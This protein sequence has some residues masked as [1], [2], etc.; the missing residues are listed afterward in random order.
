[1]Y[2][3]TQDINF[4]H[5]HF[6]M[7]NN[8]SILGHHLPPSKIK[9]SIS[10]LCSSTKILTLFQVTS[11]TTPSQKNLCFHR[12]NINMQICTLTNLFLHVLNVVHHDF[13]EYI[14]YCHGPIKPFSIFVN[15]SVRSLPFTYQIFI[16]SR[17]THFYLFI[18][19]K[20]FK[21]L[22]SFTPATYT[23]FHFF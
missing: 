21:G 7:M 22:E 16:L 2:K 15:K 9:L 23:F 8:R 10:H 13:C 5:V 1:M 18:F 20:A 14:S 6:L 17:S 19:L 3:R 11:V 4:Q 12:L